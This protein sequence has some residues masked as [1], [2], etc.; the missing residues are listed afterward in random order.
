MA[1]KTCEH[2]SHDYFLPVLFLKSVFLTCW[3]FE[4]SRDGIVTLLCGALFDLMLK[5]AHGQMLMFLSF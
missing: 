2:P 5:V 1:P 4:K 3:W